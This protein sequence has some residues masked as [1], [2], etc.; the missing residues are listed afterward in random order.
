M[1]RHLK[2]KAVQKEKKK[3]LIWRCLGTENEAYNQEE[4]IVNDL[5]VTF[6]HQLGKGG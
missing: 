4:Q 3:A 1:K 5:P 6:L 2:K